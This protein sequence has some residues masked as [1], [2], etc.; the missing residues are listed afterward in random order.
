MSISTATDRLAFPRR[1][2]PRHLVGGLLLAI[3]L[4]AVV[5]AIAISSTATST[6]QTARLATNHPTQSQPVAQPTSAPAPS[7]P[8]GTFRDP[9]T[10]ALLAVGNPP[11]PQ[12]DPARTFRDPVTHALL[13]V[14][15][16]PAP[17]AEPGLGHR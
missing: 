6:S 2:Q 13:A 4:I 11:V 12:A 1:V 3:G 16:P 8:S 9:V 15:N 17:Q 7:V 10:H 14:G 5:V